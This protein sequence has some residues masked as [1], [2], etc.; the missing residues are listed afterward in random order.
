MKNFRY[1]FTILDEDG[2][3]AFAGDIDAPD[4]ETS[5]AAA[6]EQASVRSPGKRLH[7]T[8]AALLTL[9]FIQWL[10]SRAGKAVAA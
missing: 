6:R 1:A 8:S 2:E 5:L 4:F 7:V 3:L 9:G 10:R